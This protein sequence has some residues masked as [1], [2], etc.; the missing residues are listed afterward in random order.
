M[1][2]VTTASAVAGI[3][4][5]I[6]RLYP[7]LDPGQREIIAH[8]DGP[9]LGIA[10]PGSGKT[11]VVAL[12]GVNIL[13]LG[14]AAPEEL[15]LC[16][17]NRAAAGELR[18]RF[19]AVATAAGYAG[20]LARVRI[21]TIHSLCRALLRAQPELVG[22][23]PGFGVLG[24]A[25]QPEFLS[26]HFDDIFGPDLTDLE[27]GGW[28]WREHRLV[29][30]NARRYI[31][32]ICDEL[33]DPWALVDSGHPF[34]AALG[35]CCLRYRDRLQAE[36]AVDFEHLQVWAHVLLMDDPVARRISDGVRHLICDE[37]QDLSQIQERLLL[38][39]A[40]RHGNICVVG[41]EDQSLYRFRGASAG[42]LMQFPAHFDQGHDRRCHTV[43]LTVN[44]RSRAAIV[45]FYGG[46]IA[47]AAD[48]R[49]PDGG[50]PP[51]RYAKTVTSHDPDGYGDHP[52][53]IAVAAPDAVEE[54]RQLAELLRFLKRRGVID[55]YDQVALLLHSVQEHVA[56]PYLDALERGGIPVRR[57]PAGSGD[58][59][60]ERRRRRA[61]TVTTVH[62]A[63]GQEWDVVI[64]GSLGFD[65]ADVDPVGRELLPYC[66]RPSLEPADRIASFDHARQSYVAFSRARHLLA[67]T[68][69]GPV[70]PRFQGVWDGLPR[71]DELDHGSLAALAGQRFGAPTE[72][73]DV[74]V[75]GA[76]PARR[77]IARLRRVDIRWG[78][79][80]MRR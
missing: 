78:R 58:H 74:D 66:P 28:R 45:G 26:R 71:W 49:N 34:H 4:P 23:R 21:G 35:R 1:N 76:P 15:A 3:A 55:G 51:Y 69:G 72:D 57:A 42:N 54:G 24:E 22:L 50:G 79:A 48:W 10:G 25:E 53:V 43:A 62:Q 31:A 44:Y 52:A 61:V 8:L 5:A 16:T 46:W 59:R 18:E 77:V 2:T 39:L 12:R 63:K 40:H 29:M 27:R 7:D 75:A 67:L 36:N 60:Q 64:V 33:I 73:R 80:A 9:T 41:D 13:L 14:K 6:L 30:Q 37:Y 38:R 32:R 19:T 65:N 20:D 70:H 68:A 56:R 11:L 47:T 17:Y